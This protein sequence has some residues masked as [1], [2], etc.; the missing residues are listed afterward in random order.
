MAKKQR[1]NHNTITMSRVFN[2]DEYRNDTVVEIRLKT[3]EQA[4]AADKAGIAV[5]EKEIRNNDIRHSYLFI[6][7]SFT[8]L[9][10]KIKEVA[11]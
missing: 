4:I 3:V 6:Q 2:F 10:N 8:D 11:L 7:V 9:I 5:Y 1:L